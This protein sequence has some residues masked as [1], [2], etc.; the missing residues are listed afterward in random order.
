MKW[1]INSI[2]RRTATT[3]HGNSRIYLRQQHDNYTKEIY[4][5]ICLDPFQ[6]PLN[7]V[8]L[9]GPMNAR[10]YQLVQVPWHQSPNVKMFI[11]CNHNFIL[12]FVQHIYMSTRNEGKQV[13]E[14]SGVNLLFFLACTELSRCRHHDA[15]KSATTR[16]V[17][18]SL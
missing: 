8:K 17:L 13:K 14:T 9:C 10:L 3:S 7:R 4:R 11:F 6:S 12:Q 1:A 15:Y 18:V 16:C 5:T 2:V